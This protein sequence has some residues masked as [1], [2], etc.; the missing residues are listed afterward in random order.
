MDGLFLGLHC[1]K[2]V[3]EIWKSQVSRSSRSS[4][5]FAPQ[6]RRKKIFELFPPQ[7]RTSRRLSVS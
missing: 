3:A 1:L 6:F 7:A 5:R 4:A 2:T